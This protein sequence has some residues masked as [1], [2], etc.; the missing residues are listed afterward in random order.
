[1]KKLKMIIILLI[2]CLIPNYVLASSD[3]SVMVKS[4]SELI[5]CL[6]TTGVCRLDTGIQVNSVLAVT[7]DVI[8]DLNGQVLMPAD[9]FKR[10]GGF[11]LVE[12]GAKLVVNDSKG[13]GKISTGSNDNSNVW[14]AIQLARDNTDTSKRAEL[15]VNGGTIEGFYYGIVGN[16]SYH[17][18][19]ITI[20]SGTVVG[21]NDKD[22]VG[23]YHPQE[24]TLIINDG[25]IKGGTGIEMRSGSLTINNGTV[26]ATSPRFIKVVTGGGSTTNGVAVAVAQHTTK[27][28]IAVTINNG[29][30]SGQ[31]AFYE[32]NPH[33]NSNEDISK[34]SLK[35]NGGDFTGTAEGVSTVY[36]EDF[37][38]FISGGTFNKSVKDYTIEDDTVASTVIDDTEKKT[39]DVSNTKKKPTALIIIVCLVLVF[40]AVYVY[41]KKIR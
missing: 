4:E 17:N 20:N 7:A 2:A 8:L 24:G 28:P 32:W 30:F 13:T 41:F 38:N 22:S 18:T 1:M 6:N 33:K 19:M 14:G 3:D 10:E 9:G 26:T 21:L 40:V 12:R 34:I 39:A 25:I 36:S 27:N 23:I 15:T 31:Y 35:I 16:G 29:V 11:I 37:T 5:N